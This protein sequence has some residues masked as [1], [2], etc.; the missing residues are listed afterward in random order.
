MRCVCL[1]LLSSAS[2]CVCLCK[3]IRVYI[4]IH[5]HTHTHTYIHICVIINTCTYMLYELLSYIRGPLCSFCVRILGVIISAAR[6][7]GFSTLQP[8]RVYAQSLSL[9]LSLSHARARALSLCTSDASDTYAGAVR[10]IGLQVDGDRR[11]SHNSDMC[12]ACQSVCKE[13]C[14][15]PHLIYSVCKSCIHLQCVQGLSLSARNLHISCALFSDCQSALCR[16]S[17]WNSVATG[18]AA[19]RQDLGRTSA[20]GVLRA[21]EADN[22]QQHRNALPDARRAG[23]DRMLSA[24]CGNQLWQKRLWR[25]CRAC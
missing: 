19:P 18:D 23:G 17:M 12:T 13:L 10:V 1:P 15:F 21:G 2:M 24:R 4:H 7:W 5:V 8:S 3:H 14:S 11:R 25:L 22:G 9:A 16:S 20:H 6:S